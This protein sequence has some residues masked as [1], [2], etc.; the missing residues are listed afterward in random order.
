M[1]WIL[2]PL[3]IIPLNTYAVKFKSVME[4]WIGASIEELTSKWGYPAHQNDV[5]DIDSNTRIF[6]YRSYGG[7]FGGPK[8][9]IVSFTI[10]DN[11]VI[12][13]KYRGGHCPKI[14]R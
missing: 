7:A 3:L 9:C 10:R 13:Y 11:I 6:T 5:V 12:Q 2:L 14:R 8:A 1:R 4:E